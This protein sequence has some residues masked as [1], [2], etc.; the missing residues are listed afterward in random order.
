[1]TPE[2]QRIAIA[3][4]RGWTFLHR[5]SE[6]DPD[7]SRTSYL[8]GRSPIDKRN[9]PYVDM[10]KE[11]VPDYLSD[12]NAI[13]SAIKT[14][15]AKDHQRFIQILTLDVLKIYPLARDVFCFAI[16]T[17]EISQLCETFLRTI[18]KWEEDK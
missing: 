17:A 8:A 9:A 7:V 2:K 13:I 10:Y 12:R 16:L 11:E 4:A 6:L 1:M 3:E 18:G 14:L 15:P 5:E